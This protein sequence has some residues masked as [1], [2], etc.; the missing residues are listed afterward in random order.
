MRPLIR[1]TGVFCFILAFAGNV[2]GRNVPISHEYGRVIIRN[3]SDRAGLAPVR[4]DH[5]LHRARYTC[6]LC[7][8]DIGFAMEAN[9]TKINADT[10][11][12]GFYCGACHNGTRGY[13][14]K[15]I[16]PSCSLSVTP[17]ENTGCNRCH[18]VGKDV[19]KE[20][21]YA[22]FTETL[23]K[24]NLGDLVDWEEAEARGLIRPV[25]SLAGV[26][27]QRPPLNIQKDFSIVSKSL[28]MPD[29]IFSHKKHAL[30]NGCELCHPD[31][32]PSV[33]KG[34]ARY[35]MFQI[36]YGEYCGL[37]HDRVAFPLIDCQKCHAK[38]VRR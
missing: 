12:K 23:P 5:W 4:F 37:C 9:A 35:S 26:S 3:F 6:R 36:S 15:K 20:Y 25:D 22:S 32:F 34:T 8:V 31:I 27:I 13:G 33:K 21:D 11:I 1:W 16:F 7:H 2:N 17:G 14:W 28:W 38:A 18:C 30:W 29:I 10:N 19:Q 24:Q